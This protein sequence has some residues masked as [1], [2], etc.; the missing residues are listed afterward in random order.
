MGE[1]NQLVCALDLSA[2]HDEDHAMRV[3]HAYRGKLQCSVS[4]PRFLFDD[5]SLCAADSGIGGMERDAPHI[6]RDPV[7]SGI[8]DMGSNRAS[9][10]DDIEIA[11]ARESPVP[12]VTC[13]DAQ[14]I[15]ALL[16]LAAV[17]VEQAERKWIATHRSP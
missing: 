8:E 13:K 4:D 7:S 14:T 6:H 2:V 10:R 5:L 1:G 3:A 15:P 11:L 17:R 16:E 12:E 9:R